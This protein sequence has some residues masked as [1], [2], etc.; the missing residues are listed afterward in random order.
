MAKIEFYVG[1]NSQKYIAVVDDGSVPREGEFISI[2]STTYK[3][4]RVTWAIDH[5]TTISGASLRANVELS[6]RV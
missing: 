1:D 6:E 4:E 2:R 3:V 5:T